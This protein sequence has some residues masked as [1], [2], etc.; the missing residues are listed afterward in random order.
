MRRSWPAESSASS[1][2]VP[3]TGRRA[4]LPARASTSGYAAPVTTV[5]GDAAAQAV[6]PGNGRWSDPASWG[7]RLVERPRGRALFLVTAV[8]VARSGIGL[9]DHGMIEIAQRFPAPHPSY[10]GVSVL[11]PAI[12]WAVGVDG[13]LEW[14]VLHVPIVLAVLVVLVVLLGR[15]G[16]PEPL[17]LVPEL[18]LLASAVPV[19]LLGRIGHYDV[20]FVL[21]S[22]A[23]VLGPSWV[24]PLVGGVVLGATNVEQA[25]L[26]LAAAAAC[27]WSLSVGVGRRLAVAAATTLAARSL[28]EWWYVANDVAADPRAAS[29]T[30]LLG[31]SV[32]SF[33]RVAPVAVASWYGAAW[34]VV[35]VVVRLPP[36]GPRRWALV[37]GLLV[38]P[39]LAS[40]GTLDGTRVFAMVS[41]APLLVVATWL[42]RLDPDGRQAPVVAHASRAAVGLMLITPGLATWAR[43]AIS[44][45][46]ASLIDRISSLV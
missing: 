15:L 26:A 30:E 2:D 4:G 38:V 18:V 13:D 5:D 14:V 45:P 25:A 29:F 44:I 27:G 10:K 46:W 23:V 33:L 40:I 12:A 16:T 1:P 39:A 17:R 21:A 34:V 32:G 28:V 42:A 43:G 11:S 9:Y 37:V 36:P 6:D 22:A 8:V 35:I 20:W 31:D 3:G 19:V 24:G 7:R 41:L